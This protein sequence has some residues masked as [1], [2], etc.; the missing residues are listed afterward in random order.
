[1]L[2]Q[3]QTIPF[4]FIFFFLFLTCIIDFITKNYCNMITICTHVAN[5]MLKKKK[6]K[7]TSIFLTIILCKVILYLYYTGTHSNTSQFI[8]IILKNK[9][10]I[11]SIIDTHSYNINL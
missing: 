4:F 8:Q 7:K 5:P 10:L 11:I 3:T 6:K 1:M 2:E 9:K